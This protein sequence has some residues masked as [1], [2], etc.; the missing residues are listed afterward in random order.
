MERARGTLWSVGAAG[1]GERG[2]GGSVRQTQAGRVSSLHV[3]RRQG[4][5]G[6]FS[7]SIFI[8]RE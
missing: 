5:P 1:G 7:G 4:A 6:Q 8:P 3:T 2:S